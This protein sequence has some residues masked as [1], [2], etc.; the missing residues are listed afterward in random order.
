MDKLV[1]PIPSYPAQLYVFIYDAYFLSLHI[2]FLD[3]TKNN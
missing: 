2:Y 1:K 3:F